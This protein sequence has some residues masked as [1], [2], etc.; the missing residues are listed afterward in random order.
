VVGSGRGDEN[1]QQHSAT[2]GDAC[3]LLS[4]SVSVTGIQYTDVTCIPMY[5]TQ[6]LFITYI[7]AYIVLA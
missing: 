6:L 3:L 5:R 4:T 7:H 1:S 2:A